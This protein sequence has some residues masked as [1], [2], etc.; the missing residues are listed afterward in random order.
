MQQNSS[1]PQMSAP[2]P[3][4]DATFGL[5]EL[6]LILVGGAFAVLIPAFFWRK[7]RV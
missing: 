4:V 2:D 3:P 5:R 1:L 6:A 7:L